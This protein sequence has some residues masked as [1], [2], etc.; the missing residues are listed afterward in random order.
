MHRPMLCFDSDQPLM[1]RIGLG[2]TH[3]IDGEN[4][5]EVRV[6]PVLLLFKKAAHSCLPAPS[7]PD[8]AFLSLNESPK[9]PLPMIRLPC[10]RTI[11]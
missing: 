3:H 8:M 7:E 11:R 2:L 1:M 9:K 4:N 10:R 5:A 6:V